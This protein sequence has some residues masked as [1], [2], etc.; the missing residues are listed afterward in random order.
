ML[1]HRPHHAQRNLLTRT[2]GL[3]QKFHHCREHTGVPGD[4]RRTLDRGPLR[5][6][7]CPPDQLVGHEYVEQFQGIVG[8]A[9]FQP[10]HRGQ[11]CGDLLLVR[12]T[13][14]LGRR[15]V[16]ALLRQSDQPPLGHP[17]HIHLAQVQPSDLRYSVQGHDHAAPGRVLPRFAPH[18]QLRPTATLGHLQ[19]FLQLKGLLAG[20]R[21]RQGGVQ[22]GLRLLTDAGHLVP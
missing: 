2:L 13:V 11:K 6:L 1:D 12:Q 21:P 20:H 5:G 17:A 4:H 16:P 10:P 3:E 18:L 14:K 22:P 7:I 9:N 8:G 19:Q 15:L